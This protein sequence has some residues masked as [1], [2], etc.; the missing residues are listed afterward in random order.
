MT[1]RQQYD[2]PPHSYAKSNRQVPLVL[3]HTDWATTAPNPMG[4]HIVAIGAITAAPAKT[5]A[6]DLEEFVH[7]AG[8]HGVVYASL[9]T[10]AIPGQLQQAVLIVP[11]KMD[12]LTH[13][14]ARTHKRMHAH[15]QTHHIG[16]KD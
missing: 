7:S 16:Q 4:P 3:M 2:I 6:P 9:G 10:T 13:M 14:H 12:T 1:C 8:A 15:M 5:L 11:C